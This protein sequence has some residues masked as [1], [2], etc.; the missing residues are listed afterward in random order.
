MQVA[1]LT[2]LGQRRKRTAG[3]G[4][5]A[6][7]EMR[8]TLSRHCEVCCG[9][10][11]VDDDA[12]ARCSGSEECKQERLLLCKGVVVEEEVSSW[13]RRLFVV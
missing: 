6:G 10:E 8:G 1:S 12:V 11:V 3:R 2:S 7:R 9:V 13:L 4:P 5:R